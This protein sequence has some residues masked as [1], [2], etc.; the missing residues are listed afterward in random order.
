MISK[1]YSFV[2]ITLVVLSCSTVDKGPWKPLFNETDFSEFEQRGGEAIYRVENGTIIGT[3][4]PN[5]Q[6]SFMCTRKSYSDFTLECEVFVDTSLNSGIQIRSNAYLNGRVHGYQVEIDDKH[7]RL[8]SGGI[9]DEARRGWLNNLMDNEAGRQAYRINEWNLYRIEAIGN[10]VKTWVNGVMC[11]NLVD[12][13]DASGFIAFQVHNVNVVRE[14]WTEG[15]E[16]K[17]R[18]IRIMTEE[19]E[20]YRFLGEDPVPPREVLLTNRLTGQ[21]E[22]QGWELLFDG[23]STEKWRGAGLTAFPETGWEAV[24]G[25]IQLTA[26]DEA[27]PGD[28]LTVEEYSD[29]EISLEFKLAGGSESGIKYLCRETEGGQVTGLEFQLIDDE[30]NPDALGGEDG[31]RTCGSLYDLV[32]ARTNKMLRGAGEW[33][34]ANIRASGNRVSHFLNGVRVLEYNRDTEDFKVPESGHIHLEDH[35]H[36]VAF[37]NI[38]IRKLNP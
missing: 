4:V 11:A 12:D 38:K 25:T 7:W 10:S 5:T 27:G 30:N 23:E 37:R 28:I 2:T 29:F 33:N 20:K 19:L 13:A 16:V 3:T 31:S 34:M 8:W 6:N 1:I 15:V 17:W 22:K 18:N 9:Y 35:G 36:E 14:P 21:E 32:P 26:G 24:D